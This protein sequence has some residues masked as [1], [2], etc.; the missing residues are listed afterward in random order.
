MFNIASSPFPA[1]EHTLTRFVA[2]FFEQK[3]SAATVKNYLAAVRHT[4]IA[5]SLGNPKI[6]SMPQLEYMMNGLKRSAT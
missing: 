1:L 3:L 5:L 4:Q 2:F 6:G